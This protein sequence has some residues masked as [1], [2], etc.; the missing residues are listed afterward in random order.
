MVILFTL[1][2][3]DSDVSKDALEIFGQISSCPMFANKLYLRVYLPS[4][5]F[6][7]TNFK[8]TL[9]VVRNAFPVFGLESRLN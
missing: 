9:F 6:S 8:Y 1:Q 5:G 4:D 3:K 2:V 7:V